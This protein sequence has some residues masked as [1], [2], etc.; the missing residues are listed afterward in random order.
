MGVEFSP[1]K[2]KMDVIG[3]LSTRQRWCGLSPSTSSTHL[4]LMPD[5]S[6]GYG[7]KGPEGPAPPIYYTAKLIFGLGGP[8][9]LR[10]HMKSPQGD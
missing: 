2:V 4:R 8:Q 5:V 9:A 3:A 10:S 1:E 6:G 7:G